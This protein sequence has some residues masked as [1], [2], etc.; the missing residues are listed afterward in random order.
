VTVNSEWTGSGNWNPATNW[1]GSNMPGSAGDTAKFLGVGTSPV[2]LNGTRTV[3]ALV[4]S[5]GATANYTI[6][7]TS[8]DNLILDN[9]VPA[10]TAATVTVN[11]GAHTIAAPV[12]LN[13]DV[14]ITTVGSGVLTVSGKISGSGKMLTK[15]GSGALVLS[16]ASLASAN[17]YSG[18]SFVDGGTLAITSRYALPAGHDV[19][20]QGNGILILDSS[21]LPTIAGG[22]PALGGG[23]GNV[24]AVPEPGTLILLAVGA[25]M[26]VA[27]WLRRRARAAK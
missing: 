10:P 2:A 21:W 12:Q 19:T 14:S 11:S 17:T 23:I 22:T 27:A 8:S 18:G 24:S 7:G 5:S 6:S 13:S 1:L 16:T 25:L 26:G 20:I 9:N 3:G 15:S 4:M